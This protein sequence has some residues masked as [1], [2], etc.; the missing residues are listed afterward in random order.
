MPSDMP[1]RVNFGSWTEFVKA[2]GKEPRKSEISIRARKNS[3]KARVGKA[4][5]NNKGGRIYDKFGYVQVWKPKHPNCKTAGYIHEHRFV[6]SEYLGRPLRKGENVHHINGNRA[7]NRIENLELW[8][9]VQ[10]SGQRVKDKIE[11]AKSFLREYG[12]EI[13]GNIHEN[14]ELLEA[15]C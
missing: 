2:C 13:I 10:P 4:G 6:M 12:Y 11:W 8:T 14:P 9:T 3:I 5:G 1:I 15:T 7:D